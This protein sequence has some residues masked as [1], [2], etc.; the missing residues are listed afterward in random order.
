LDHLAYD[1]FLNKPV[2]LIFHGSTTK[3]CAQPCE[4]LLLV[5]RTLYDHTLQCQVA[6]A[7]EDFVRMMRGIYM[8]SHK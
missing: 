6:S 4:H 8:E 3:K 5:V 1:A 2:G 7:R